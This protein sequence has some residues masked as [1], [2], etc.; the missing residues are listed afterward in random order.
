MSDPRA[1]RPYRRLNLH[2]VAARADGR[3]SAV[4]TSTVGSPG[5]GLL[6]PWLAAIAAA[7][8]ILGLAFGSG[9]SRL[10]RDQSGEPAATTGAAPHETSTDSPAPDE[11]PAPRTGDAD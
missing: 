2:S 10:V 11:I 1:T 6:W 8:V 7:G 9:L 3:T 4:R 5:T